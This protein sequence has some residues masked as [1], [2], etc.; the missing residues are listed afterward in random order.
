M[1][2]S[3]P[4]TQL[5]YNKCKDGY[6]QKKYGSSYDRAHALCGKL[7]TQFL[8]TRFKIYHINLFVLILTVFALGD[9]NV[10]CDF[11]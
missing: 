1:Y 5:T 3:H 4:R 9:E 7:A 6:I 2:L 11:G 10:S 8:F